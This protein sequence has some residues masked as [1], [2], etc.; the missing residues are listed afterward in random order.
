[1]N[2]IRVPIVVLKGNLIITL[3]SALSD[4]VILHLCDDTTEAIQKHATSGLILDVSGVDILDSYMTRLI[5]DLA[6]TSRLMGVDTV[7]CGIRPNVAL[8]LIEMGIEIPG[9]Q[10]ALNLE[11]SLLLL[12]QKRAIPIQIFDSYDLDVS[13][14]LSEI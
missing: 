1:M 6:L 7:V 3:P 13:V 8:T 14:E 2:E 11:R 12:A 9:V 4:D 5:R 10:T